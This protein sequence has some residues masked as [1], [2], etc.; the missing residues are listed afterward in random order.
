MKLLLDESVPRRIRRDFPKGFDVRTVQDMGW[1]GTTNGALLALAVTGGFEAFLT[2]DKN[3]EFQQNLSDL[4]C[5][6]LS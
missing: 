2:C 6:V 5:T 1:A 4:P 3:L